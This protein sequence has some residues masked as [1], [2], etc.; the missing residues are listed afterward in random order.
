MTRWGY[1]QVFIFFLLDGN[2]LTVDRKVDC[3]GWKDTLLAMYGKL[4]DSS[5]RVI[6][7]LVLALLFLMCGWRLA[8]FLFFSLLFFG[9]PPH[10]E[11]LWNKP[12]ARGLDWPIV[13]GWNVFF[14]AGL[15]FFLPLSAGIQLSY[16]L[17]QP[18]QRTNTCPF[19]RLRI[20]STRNRLSSSA[21]T[22]WRSCS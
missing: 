14:Y 19:L 11:M 4:L 1:N 6:S 10:R 8:C 2:L 5:M 7:V 21:C 13:L 9:G 12:I 22:F 15:F 20:F 18:F 16:L 3:L 17:G